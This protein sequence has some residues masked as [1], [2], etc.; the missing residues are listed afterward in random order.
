MKILTEF[1]IAVE[2]LDHKMPL[3]AVN[4]CTKNY[5]YLNEIESFLRFYQQKEN[6]SFFDLG[7]AGAGIIE[8]FSGRGYVAVGVDGT[9]SVFRGAGSHNWNKWYNE[10][11][12][13]A[14]IGKDFSIVDENNHIVQFDC[15]STIEVPEHISYEDQPQF[16]LNIRKHLKDDGIVIFQAGNETIRTEPRHIGVREDEEWRDLFS[17]TGFCLFDEKKKFGFPLRNTPRCALP[18]E[19][20]DPNGTPGKLRSYVYALKKNL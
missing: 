18:W 20:N 12:F 14:D 6:P 9:D 10:K 4:D 17:Q 3:G 11:L 8:V 13:L 2:S 15:I 16:M 19:D 5:D 1:P 7:C